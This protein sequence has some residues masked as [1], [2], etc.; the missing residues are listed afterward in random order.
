MRYVQVKVVD[1]SKSTTF[2]LTRSRACVT[3]VTV[4]F[5][6]LQSKRKTRHRTK[7]GSQVFFG[8]PIAVER[9]FCIDPDIQTFAVA[10][11]GAVL[12]HRDIGFRQLLEIERRSQTVQRHRL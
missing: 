3:G 7:N 5:F 6:Q 4:A 9:L 2:D 8:P 11:S 1:E 10:G 12:S